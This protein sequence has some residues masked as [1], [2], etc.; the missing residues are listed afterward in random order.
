[1]PKKGYPKKS[2][3]CEL[4]PPSELIRRFNK[5]TRE[6]FF[7]CTAAKAKYFL[8]CCEKTEK[9]S[10]AHFYNFYFNSEISL[11]IFQLIKSLGIDN[12]DYAMLISSQDVCL[13]CLYWLA[14]AAIFIQINY[15]VN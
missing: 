15:T 2:T 12:A 11:G 14:A 1:M 5:I 6:N 8:E 3:L 13:R 7:N 10:S 9:K 4:K